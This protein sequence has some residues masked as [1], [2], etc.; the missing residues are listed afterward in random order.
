MAA[1]SAVRYNHAI[2]AY[3]QHLLKQGKGK[4]V[5]LVASMRKLLVCLN[6]MVR[7]N[8]PWSDEQV[9]S[10]LQTAPS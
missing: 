5:A 9:T 1:L 3:Y 7:H 6:A 10:Q 2:Q 4:K 8:Q